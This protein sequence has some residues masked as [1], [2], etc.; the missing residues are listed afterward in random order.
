MG[1]ELGRVR[2]VA[3]FRVAV[4]RPRGARAPQQGPPFRVQPTGADGVPAAPNLTC[5]VAPGGREP[6]ASV[7]RMVAVP[8]APPSTPPQTPLTDAPGEVNGTR[9]PSSRFP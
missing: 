5:T 1:A 8:P 6:A 3:P 9:Q 4:N 2:P 7:P